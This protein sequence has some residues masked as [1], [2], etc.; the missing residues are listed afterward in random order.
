MDGVGCSAAD[1]IRVPGETATSSDTI[2]MRRVRGYER[3]WER[4][5]GCLGGLGSTV[6]G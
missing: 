1:T 2:A 5:V 3:G 6:S 4:A